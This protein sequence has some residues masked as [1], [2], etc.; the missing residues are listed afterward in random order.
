MSYMSVL[1]YPCVPTC[2]SALVSENDYEQ[3]RLQVR[4]LPSVLSLFFHLQGKPGPALSLLRCPARS[5]PQL[6]PQRGSGGLREH[7]AEAAHGLTLHVGDHVRVG[8]QCDRDPGVA[9]DLLENL[10]MLPIL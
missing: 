6:V 3:R 10:G 1:L 5:V 2:R 4:V 7:P 9:E 8:G